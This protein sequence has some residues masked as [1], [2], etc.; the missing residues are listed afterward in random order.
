MFAKVAFVILIFGSLMVQVRSETMHDSAVG[1]SAERIQGWL[2]WPLPPSMNDTFT[3]RLADP[4]LSAKLQERRSSLLFRLTKYD[5][6]A[7]DKTLP[8]PAFQATIRGVTDEQAKDPSRLLEEVVQAMK[9]LPFLPGLTP[10]KDI[11]STKLGSHSAAEV[12]LQWSLP[13]TDRPARSRVI[14]VVRGNFA[15]SITLTDAPQ[16]GEDCTKEFQELMK[17]VKIEP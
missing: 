13:K 4:E 16:A 7:R 2:Q 9:K 5:E 3:K 12:E 10:T 11:V 6:D 15:I 17:S 8:N 1:F 14:V